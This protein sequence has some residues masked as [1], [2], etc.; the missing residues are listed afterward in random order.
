MQNLK[1]VRAVVPV[2]A[3]VAM[4]M[5]L[6]ACADEGGVD[7]AVASMV[8]P[9]ADSFDKT[10]TREFYRNSR[11]GVPMPIPARQFNVPETLIVSAL[12][13][14][15][16]VGTPGEPERVREIW[17]S[18]DAW[19]EDTPVRLVFAVDGA[20][21]FNFPS[22]VPFTQPDDDSGFQDIYADGGAGV[23]GHLFRPLV[24]AVYAAQIPKGDGTFTR[25]I[26]FYNGDGGLILGVYASEPGKDANADA[27]AGFESTWA[28]LETMPRICQAS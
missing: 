1:K 12:P 4:G 24:K 14:D 16:F 6:S 28:L 23:H 21:T 15:Q 20:H 11:P 18:I 3:A 26:S 7:E 8:A 9:C 5:G 27:V 22:L 13:A 17:H 2:I 19:G 10:M 25:T